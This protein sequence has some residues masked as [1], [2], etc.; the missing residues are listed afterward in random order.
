MTSSPGWYVAVLVVESAVDDG[1]AR[2]PLVDLQY[3]LVRA[4]NP[5]AAHRRALELG[6]EAEHSYQNAGGANVTWTCVG[7]HD[8]C[9]VFA[10]DLVDGVE[11]Y[12]RLVR[13]DASLH[14]VPKE[15]LSIFRSE[16]NKHKTAQDLLDGE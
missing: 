4:A 3:R 7:L 12:S 11:V 5:E 2:E 15:R 6:R 14:V 8:L 9:E 10:R 16:A 1:V 13:S